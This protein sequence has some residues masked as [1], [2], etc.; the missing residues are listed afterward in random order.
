MLVINQLKLIPLIIFQ[1]QG[2]LKT[3]QYDIIP[4]LF[5]LP[6]AFS[7]NTDSDGIGN[8]IHYFCSAI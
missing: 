6:S 2:P 4:L 7:L 1:Q 5:L 3:E 8:I